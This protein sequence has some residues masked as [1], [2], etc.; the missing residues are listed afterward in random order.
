MESEIKNLD[1]LVFKNRNK[2][3]GAYANRKNY[4]RY[5]IYA[6]VAAIS[7]FFMGISVP[8]IAGY[9]N[10]LNNDE[11]PVVY[12]SDTLQRVREH[13]MEIKLPEP[14]KKTVTEP[15]FRP[16]LVV[17]DTNEVTGDL[18][19]LQD[20]GNN[21]GIIDTTGGGGGGEVIDKTPPVIEP[22]PKETFIIVEEMPEFPGG[23]KGRL[24]YLS[25][26]VAYPRIAIETG[27]QG[28]V[29]VGFVVDESGKVVEPE[30]WR[31]I[32]GGCDEE[33]M[34]VVQN[35]PKWKPGRQNGKEV[36]V[37]FSMAIN[38]TLK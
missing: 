9:V 7:I 18:A 5:M 27:I 38:F 6:M 21:R 24:K 23:E 29:Y 35:M 26:N 25:E 11:G 13:T 17:S 16:P 15:V 31:G 30:L 37:K 1:D 19:D 8:L 22:T 4:S 20:K 3:Y 36:R 33:A 32:G 14:E 34:R 28:P 12:I 10:R 2:N